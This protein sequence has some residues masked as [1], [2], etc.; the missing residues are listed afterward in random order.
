MA[1]CLQLYR[2][3]QRKKRQAWLADLQTPITYYQNTVQYKAFT[4]TNDYEPSLSDE[5]PIRTGDSVRVH[6]Y[7]DEEWAYGQNET[8]AIQ[9]TIHESQ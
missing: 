2:R 6:G 9:G 5:M 3:Q 8:L 4:A 1:I 7:Y